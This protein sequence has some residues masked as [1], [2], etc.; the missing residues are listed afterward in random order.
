[1]KV[2]LAIVVLVVTGMSAKADTVGLTSDEAAN[3]VLVSTDSL[4]RPRN[5]VVT[6]A[7][8]NQNPL[9]FQIAL[10]GVVSN[11]QSIGMGSNYTFSMLIP[12]GGATSFSIT[13]TGVGLI[14]RSVFAVTS[15][16]E[17]TSMLLLG[18]GLIGLGAAVR[19][20]LK[21]A[22]GFRVN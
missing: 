8:L 2:L 10:N 3:L 13:I 19:W 21:R 5:A 22:R 20:Q 11:V 15:V 12:W 17:P 6:I 4:T 14:N 18:S 16:T 1:M 9:S 7:N